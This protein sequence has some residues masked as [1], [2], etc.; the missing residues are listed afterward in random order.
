MKLR[1]FLTI[2]SGLLPRRPAFAGERT[3]LGDIPTLPA[4]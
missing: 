4:P 2:T 3:N 1:A